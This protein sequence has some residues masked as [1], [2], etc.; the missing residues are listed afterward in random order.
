M[1]GTI[2]NTVVVAGNETD[3]NTD[4]N[5]DSEDT[6]VNGDDSLSIIKTDSTDPVHVG[7]NL[8][9]TVTVSNGGPSN[10]TNVQVVDT[11]P[12]GVS[13]ISAVAS[14]GTGCNN[15]ANTVT[16]DLGTI[17]PNQSATITITVLVDLALNP[18]GSTIITNTAT[19]TSTEDPQG[20]QTEEDTAVNN[21]VPVPSLNGWGMMIFVVLAGLSAAYYLR[22][23]TESK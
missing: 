1:R 7:Q 11:L 20:P 23:Q 2:T 8:I 4:N 16:C 14:Q 15:V 13:F 18:G 6:Q 9:Y 21:P 3:P 19:V 22:R 5:T 17:A 10:S 12:A